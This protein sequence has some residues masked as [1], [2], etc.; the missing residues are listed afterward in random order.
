MP[1]YAALLRG[2][3]P[4]NPNM[5]GEK[6][7]SVFESLGFKNVESIITSGNIIFSCTSKNV[8]QLERKIEKAF[9]KQLGFKSTVI[10]RT[11][12]EL[13]RLVEFNPFRKLKDSK[14][15][16]CIV[17][18]LKNIPAK[19]HAFPHKADGYTLLSMHDREI[20][21]AI[22]LNQLTSPDVMRMLEKEYGK[23]ITTCTWNTVGRILKKMNT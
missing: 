22:D 6:L 7:R 17:T 11:K 19:M 10:I 14:D 16:Y 15:I 18:F 4:T 21:T 2:I 1:Y 9:P 13:E 20:V 3:M 8:N 5:C 23:E 12:E